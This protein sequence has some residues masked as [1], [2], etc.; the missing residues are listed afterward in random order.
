VVDEIVVDK[1]ED[2]DD[3]RVGDKEKEVLVAVREGFNV[4]VTEVRGESG[5]VDCVICGGGD[6]KI[7]E[8]CVV[9]VVVAVAEDEVDETEPRSEK[10]KRKS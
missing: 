6:C 5:G 10:T 2:S 4:V 7:V 1:D 9:V 3:K 8:V